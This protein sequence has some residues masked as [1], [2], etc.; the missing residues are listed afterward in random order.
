MERVHTGGRPLSR[1]ALAGRERALDEGRTISRRELAGH[2][3]DAAKALRLRPALRQVLAELASVW[4]EQ[5]WSRLL[6]WPSNERLSER[7][8]L[9]ERAVRYAL[10]DL[11]RLEVLT[12]KDSANGKRYAIRTADGTIVDA[13]GFDLTPIVARAGEWTE[14]LRT[15][16]AAEEVRR[17]SFDHLTVCRRAV[18]EALAGLAGSY[19]DTSVQDLVAQ[20]SELEKLSPKR[21]SGCDLTSQIL[22]AWGELRRH[23]EERFMTAACAGNS[24]RHIETYN[25]FS[26]DAYKQSFPKEA[27][28][29]RQN[30]QWDMPLEPALVAEACPVV[31]D[32]APGQP[33]TP[34]TLVIL[35]TDLRASIGAHSSAWSEACAGL[36]RLR[37]AVMVLIVAQLHEDDVKSGEH[38]IQNP[39][40]Y[41]RKLVRLAIEGRYDLPSELMGMRRRRMT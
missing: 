25:G 17:R 13:F 37:A 12:P 23:A 39:G 10:R 4:G 35:G 30:E 6:V 15:M 32:F 19:P 33:L 5:P 21:R 41:F 38:R 36:G 8:G 20:A 22:D 27:E 31:H 18:A 2:A 14:L 24:S 1:A 11:I 7:T 26:S 3:R 29:V 40:G 34:E 9:S 16:A 28:A